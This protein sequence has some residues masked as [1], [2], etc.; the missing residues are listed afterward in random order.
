MSRQFFTIC[1]YF[2]NQTKWN[3]IMLLE[4]NN[5][6]STTM[7]VLSALYVEPLYSSI[8]HY[9][10]TK[11]FI[12]WIVFLIVEYWQHLLG[13][14]KLCVLTQLGV[15]AHNKALLRGQHDSTMTTNH[16]QFGVQ[17]SST[18]HVVVIQSWLIMNLSCTC[19]NLGKC[20]QLNLVE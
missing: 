19:H 2:I 7:M 1:M 20:L 18:F 16:A 3:A 12:T 8:M 15:P 17:L 14:L 6:F 9:P 4:G 11:V 5:F 10:S 13:T